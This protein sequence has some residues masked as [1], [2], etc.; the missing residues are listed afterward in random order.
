MR[1]CNSSPLS[2][3]ICTSVSTQPAVRSDAARRNAA[4]ESYART[5]NPADSSSSANESRTDASSST[6]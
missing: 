1:R 4:A 5:E 2:S 6:T 3:G